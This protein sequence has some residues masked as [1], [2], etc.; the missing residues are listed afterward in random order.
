MCTV[1]QIELQQCIFLPHISFVV[2]VFFLIFEPNKIQFCSK[3]KGKL[4]PRSY[5]IQSERKRKCSFLSV[6][7][8]RDEKERLSQKCYEV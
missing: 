3:S 2:T 1:M 8:A 6:F 7:A 5:T 4:S